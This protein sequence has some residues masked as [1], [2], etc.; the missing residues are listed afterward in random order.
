MLER[1]GR[2]G[3]VEEVWRGCVRLSYVGLVCERLGKVER[4]LARLGFY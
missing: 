4:D 3:E 2:I 1:L